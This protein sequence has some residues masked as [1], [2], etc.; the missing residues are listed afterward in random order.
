M[1]P[2]NDDTQ[3]GK[4]D[5]LV[6]RRILHAWTKAALTYYVQLALL[7]RAYLPALEYPAYGASS[8][9]A[10]SPRYC[11]PDFVKSGY[12]AFHVDWASLA[13]VI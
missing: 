11:K 10:C 3:P 2:H 5:D 13:I 6:P 4:D 12:N 7:W 9:E 8:V 1:R